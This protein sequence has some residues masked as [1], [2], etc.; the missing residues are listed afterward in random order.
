MGI[1]KFLARKGAVGGTAN[2]LANAFWQ[3]MNQGGFDF[4]GLEDGSTTME[5]EILKAVEF[6][7]TIRLQ[8][9]TAHRDFARE[10]T[11][12]GRSPHKGLIA[13]TIAILK[14]EA[15]FHENTLD[16]CKQFIEVI[17]EE[18]VKKKI[19]SAFLY[20]NDEANSE[21]V[22]SDLLEYSRISPD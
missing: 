20:G 13:A 18:L 10:M 6:A 11:E 3:V 12:Y 22:L 1:G 7:I 2:F 4:D 9:D 16:T 5:N 19:G 17:E 14:I 21:T 8:N 15:G